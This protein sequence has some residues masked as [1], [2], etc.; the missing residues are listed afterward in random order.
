MSNQQPPQQP[1][2]STT[3]HITVINKDGIVTDED[4]SAVT[5]YNKIGVFDVLPMHENFISLIKDELIIHK[6]NESK[7]INIKDGIMKV[8]D[9]QVKV[10]LGIQNI[11][12]GTTLP[13]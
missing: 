13:S 8:T 1:L 5:S 4:A 7:K 12:K 9:N 2:S 6:G 11:P 10:Y 3:L